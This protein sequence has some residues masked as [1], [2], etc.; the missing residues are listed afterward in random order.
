VSFILLKTCKSADVNCNSNNY[1]CQCFR[2]GIF[3]G[4]G[5]GPLMRTLAIEE[6]IVNLSVL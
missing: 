5:R 1:F 4:G 6:G 2:A 3:L